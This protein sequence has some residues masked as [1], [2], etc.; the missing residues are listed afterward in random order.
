MRPPLTASTADH[1][2]SRRKERFDHLEAYLA[3]LKPEYW[4]VFRLARLPGLTIKE[5][6]ERAGKTEY[7]IKHLVARAVFADGPEPAMPFDE[8]GIDPTMDEL[9]CNSFPPCE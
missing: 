6:A 4:E 2:A 3:Q 5:I 7:T 1:P 8:C 9:G